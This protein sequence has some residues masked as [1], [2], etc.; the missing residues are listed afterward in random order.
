ML[1]SALVLRAATAKKL[2]SAFG[3]RSA[4]VLE[5]RASLADRQDAVG[6]DARAEMHVEISSPKTGKAFLSVAL[7]ASRADVVSHSLHVEEL[8]AK[9]A[10][11]RENAATMVESAKAMYRNN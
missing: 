8:Q 2:H 5:L 6:D 1:K 7:S 4:E 11:V 9:A 3:E 10:F